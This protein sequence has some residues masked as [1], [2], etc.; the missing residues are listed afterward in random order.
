MV[1]GA[2]TENTTNFDSVIE[3]ETNEKIEMSFD[4]LVESN[5][6]SDVRY[7]LLVILALSSLTVYGLII[8]G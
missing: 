1:L 2:A 4:F 8:A 7:G 3:S 5:M 6:I